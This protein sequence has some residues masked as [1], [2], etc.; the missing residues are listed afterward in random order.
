MGFNSG[1]KGLMTFVDHWYVS[2]EQVHIAVI[3]AI[4]WVSCTTSKT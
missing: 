3:L 4:S 2:D 1:F